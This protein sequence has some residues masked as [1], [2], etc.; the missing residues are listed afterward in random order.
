VVRKEVKRSERR[1][2]LRRSE[3]APTRIPF[4]NG[5]GTGQAFLLSCSY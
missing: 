2:C 3:R 1:L 5:N 4:V